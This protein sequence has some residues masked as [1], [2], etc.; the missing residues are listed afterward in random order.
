MSSS[1]HESILGRVAPMSW[2]L[3]H[4]AAREAAVDEVNQVVGLLSSLIATE[5]RAEQPATA[6]IAEL[7]DRQAGWARAGENLYNA[8]REHIDEIRATCAQILHG[9]L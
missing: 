9:E 2:S 8:S 1:D 3:D 5:E 7:T 6:R 4:E